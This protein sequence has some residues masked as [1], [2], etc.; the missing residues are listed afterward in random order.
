VVVVIVRG[1][2]VPAL[3][4]KQDRKE[5]GD[6]IVFGDHLILLGALDTRAPLDRRSPSL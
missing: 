2:G 1:G 4:G 6:G 5:G 3:G